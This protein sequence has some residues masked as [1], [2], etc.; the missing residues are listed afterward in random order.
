M[1]KR[2]RAAVEAVLDADTPDELIDAI[3]ELSEAY[4]EHR[5]SM[6]ITTQRLEFL[7]ERLQAG[8]NKRAAARALVASDPRIGRRTAETLVYTTF[9]GQYQNPHKR[10][11]SSSDMAAQVKPET[12]LDIDAEE[13][14]L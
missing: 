7:E 8:L 2:L 13:D 10:R 6:T 4:S 3:D 14:L 12:P 1:T 5:G 11:S 9:S